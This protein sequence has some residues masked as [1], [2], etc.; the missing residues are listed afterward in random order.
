MTL[1][2]AKR[3]VGQRVAF[4]R[5]HCEPE[6]GVISSVNARYVFVRYGHQVTGTPTDPGDLTLEIGGRGE[7]V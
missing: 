4:H 1:D 7:L 3:A 6:S 5:E 2:E